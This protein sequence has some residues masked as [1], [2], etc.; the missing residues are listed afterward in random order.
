MRDRI[1]DAVAGAFSNFNSFLIA[2]AVV[3]LWAATGPRFEFSDTW[4]LV[5][6]TGTTIV[7]FL[8]VFLIGNNQQRTEQRIEKIALD[9]EQRVEALQLELA[10]IEE[11]KL[12]KIL[13]ELPTIENMLLAVRRQRNDREP[14]T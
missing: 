3:I 7:T 13:R 4:Q 14:I 9:A 10:R 11:E 1:A 12:D 6:N 8:A 5:I 2:L